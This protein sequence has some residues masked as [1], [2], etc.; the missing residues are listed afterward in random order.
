MMMVNH[1]KMIN[2]SLFLRFSTNL[3]P[4]QNRLQHEHEDY[5]APN[6]P[7]L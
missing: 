2:L 5:Y 1:G 6:G 4:I 7:N 3:Y